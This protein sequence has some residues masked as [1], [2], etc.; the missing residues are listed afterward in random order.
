M[1]AH[2]S[3]RKSTAPTP[4][5]PTT[6]R[7]GPKNIARNGPSGADD[8]WPDLQGPIA[9][10]DLTEHAQP[11]PPEITP[12]PSGPKGWPTIEGDDCHWKT[13][14]QC[15][16]QA[17]AW[18]RIKTNCIYI[19]VIG[20]GANDAGQYGRSEAMRQQLR[21]RY[22]VDFRKSRLIA[23][24]PPPGVTARHNSEP[25]LYNLLDITKEQLAEMKKDQ[26]LS[27]RDVTMQFIE[28]EAR[29]PKKLGEWY[30][31]SFPDPTES[32]IKRS[33]TN[34]FLSDYLTDGFTQMIRQDP[35]NQ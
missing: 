7:N 13:K 1:P 22:Q 35:H 15:P 23:A 14:G 29:P 8:L 3:R 34:G 19:N 9:P 12:K 33:F 2:F 4:A 28:R 16:H 5:T 21:E 18:R 27:T 26:L 25:F 32:G 24:R 10:L 11:T 31:G 20:S 30:A 6:G 17:E